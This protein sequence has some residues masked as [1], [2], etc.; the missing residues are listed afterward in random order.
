MA[1]KPSDR[2]RQRLK[3]W[4]AQEAKNER[5][6]PATL[7]RAMFR[8]EGLLSDATRGGVSPLDGCAQP[9]KRR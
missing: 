1:T 8:G 7:A 6:R 9:E 4:H 2:Q 5:E 3:R